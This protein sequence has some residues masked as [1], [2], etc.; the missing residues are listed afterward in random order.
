METIEQTLDALCDVFDEEAERQETLLRLTRAQ[1]EAARKRD[2]PALE[3]HTEAIGVIIAEVVGAEKRRHELVRAV[4]AYYRLPEEAQTLTGLIGVAPEPWST[5][6]AEF[7]EQMRT[8]IAATRDI[9]RGNRVV[10]RRG[11]RAVGRAVAGFCAQP[12]EDAAAYDD[13]GEDRG[14]A[15]L[16]PAVLDEQG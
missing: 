5:R 7:Q 14:L 15:L 6:M 2:V 1:A 11:A 10:L 9:V 8:T 16:R 13:H 12:A 4:V 3:A